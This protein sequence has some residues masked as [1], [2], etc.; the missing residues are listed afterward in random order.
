MRDMVLL[1]HEAPVDGGFSLDALPQHG[2]LDLGCRFLNAALLTSHGVR[3]DTDA[4][5]VLSD[6]V[7]VRVEGAEVEGLN[8]DERSIAGVLR[9]A[10]EERSYREQEVQTGV[11]V[12][13]GGLEDVLDDV[14]ET[15]GDVVWMHE[16]GDAAADVEPLDDVVLVFS[17]HQEFTDGEAGLLED[18]SDRRLSLGPH[19]LHADH[20]AAVA[21][22]WLDTRGYR[23]Y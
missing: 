13:P 3:D 17:D 9:R 22:S 4:Y 10:L 1:L 6:E 16:D 20:A 18:L 19:A 21:H 2:R 23:S 12:S 5:L 8:P 15:S 7:V 11:Y 14:G